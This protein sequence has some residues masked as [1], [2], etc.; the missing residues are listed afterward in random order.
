MNRALK[1]FIITLCGF[2]VVALLVTTLVFID[3]F[4]GGVAMFI[5]ILMG[6]LFVM[7]WVLIYYGLLNKD[8]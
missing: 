4:F 2:I 5:T 3:K 7:F 1:S 6:P 8:E